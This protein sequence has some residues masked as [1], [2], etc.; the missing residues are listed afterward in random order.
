MQISIL[1]QDV[2]IR[3]QVHFY[4]FVSQRIYLQVYIVNKDLFYKTNTLL[5]T[6]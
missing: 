4:L 5:D 3:K 1:L 2:F 6:E